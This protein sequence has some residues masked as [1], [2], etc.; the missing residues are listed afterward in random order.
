MLAPHNTPMASPAV[1]D[2]RHGGGPSLTFEKATMFSS[3]RSIQFARSGASRKAEKDR[4][5]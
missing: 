4:M 2:K 3:R 5:R 1:V